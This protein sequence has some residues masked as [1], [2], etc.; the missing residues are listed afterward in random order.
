MANKI[1]VKRSAVASKVPLVGDL[2]LGELGINTHD[3]KM[4]IKKDDGL[5]SI[6]E[7]GG[8]G[9]SGN[10]TTDTT[11]FNGNLSVLDTD[12]QSALET[13][14]DLEAGTKVMYLDSDYTVTENN[15][16]YVLDTAGA[17]LPINTVNFTVT[18]PA[19]PENNDILRFVDG[20]GNSQDVP[21]LID[22]NGNTIDG[23]ADD[24]TCDVNYFDIKLI[25]NSTTNN[26][27][28]GGK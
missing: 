22:R 17:T 15:T 24:L 27:A 28:L 23:Q 20:N 10:I 25:F 5:E 14:D 8:Q 13:L 2:E 26:W 12:V 4:Y 3:G 16:L 21:V 1:L 9:T 19:T 7:I 11:N 6:V 18:L